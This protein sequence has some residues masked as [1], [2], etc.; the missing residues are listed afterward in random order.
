MCKLMYGS[1]IFYSIE[2][3][4]TN[5]NFQWELD[6]QKQSSSYG[7]KNAFL[8]RDKSLLLAT[9]GYLVSLGFW[10]KAKK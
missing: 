1:K 6:D 5:L 7:E 3:S 8:Y 4:S 2:S 10:S 9:C